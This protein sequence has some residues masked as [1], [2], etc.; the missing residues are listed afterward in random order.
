MTRVRRT[1]AD[2]AQATREALMAAGRRLFAEQGFQATGTPAIVAAADLTRGALY[3][4]F[5]DKTALFAAV[6]EAEQAAVAEH[7]TRAA[8]TS[9]DLVDQLIAGGEGFMDAMADPGRR[10][11]LLVDGPAVLGRERLE[12]GE[13]AHARRTLD[14]GLARAMDAGVLRRLPVRELSDLLGALFDR[15]ALMAGEADRA[16]WRAALAGI[17]EG[18]RAGR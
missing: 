2:R 18:L 12:A 14:E 16:A 4:H 6:V 13:A 15:A 8:A 17:I 1:N 9:G 10:R 11:I 3:H 5:E 7:I